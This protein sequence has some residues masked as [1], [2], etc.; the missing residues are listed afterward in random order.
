MLLDGKIGLGETFM[1]GDWDAEPSPK[2]LLTLLIRAKSKQLFVYWSMTF[3]IRKSLTALL[4]FPAIFWN[5]FSCLK[6]KRLVNK[7]FVG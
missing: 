7:W 5:F 4:I 2:D 6:L 1:Y 3:L